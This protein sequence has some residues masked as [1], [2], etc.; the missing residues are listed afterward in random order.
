MAVPVRRTW[1][2]VLLAAVLLM[3]GIPAM[4][5]GEGSAS[6]SH[7]EMSALPDGVGP[8]PLAA[9]PGAESAAAHGEE[10]TGRDSP[11]HPMSSHAW[12]ACLAVL[13]VGMALLAAAIARG[14][15]R[16]PLNHRTAAHPP[17]STPWT[18]PPRPPD[19]SVLCLLRT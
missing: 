7:V 16:Q 12:N 18:T 10:T 3:H 2:V 4:A 11:S 19:L 8:L 5:P 17:V 14:L 15:A 9:M 13:L 1:V 6:S